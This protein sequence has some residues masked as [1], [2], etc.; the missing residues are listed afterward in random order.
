MITKIAITNFQSHTNTQ[1]ELS[2]GLNILYGDTESGKSAIIRAVNWV[3]TNRP[4]GEKFRRH[5]TKSTVVEIYTEKSIV[6]RKKTHSINSYKVN[7][8]EFK[9]LRTQVPEEVLTALCLN[10]D[11]VQLQH[12]IYFLIDIS[13]GQ[14]GQAINK[15]TGLGITDKVLK[16][17]KGKLRTVSADLER[18]NDLLAETNKDIKDLYWTNKARHE[19]NTLLT[20]DK[21]LNKGYKKYTKVRSI[22]DQILEK[23]S[24]L[25]S[26]LSQKQIDELLV[27]D[28]DREHIHQQE[29][30]YTYKFD[31]FLLVKRNTTLLNN[32]PHIDARFIKKESYEINQ[33]V[34]YVQ[35]LAHILQSIDKYSKDK[36]TENKEFLRAQ[37]N[38]ELYLKRL[39]KCPT[40]ASI[41]K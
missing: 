39:G 33:R 3:L 1:I 21:Q 11:A 12:N 37:H 28:K 41:I 4:V 20:L 26:L 36:V 24:E 5:D 2:P 18:N 40:C 9:A 22:V 27:L 31:K 25:S 14:V 16:F 23:L 10:G 34:K 6:I 35:N 17:V 19:L 30:N 29:M 38:V 13:P 7:G 32:Y 15:V 8:K